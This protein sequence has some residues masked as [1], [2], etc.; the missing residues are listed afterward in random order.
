RSPAMPGFG[1]ALD[2][3]ARW[4][5]IDFIHA[6]ADARR[7]EL[8]NGVDAAVRVPE[9][10]V[11]CPDGS[12]S[13]ISQCA[14]ESC[15]SFLRVHSRQRGWINWQRSRTWRLH[16]EMSGAR[17]SAI[18][19]GFIS[20][21]IGLLPFLPQTYADIDERV[22]RSRQRVVRG[23]CRWPGDFGEIPQH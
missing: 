14:A 9:F 2:D 10:S 20:A 3:T 15:I 5:V 7:L 8:A 13:S 18:T 6:N 21:V 23:C 22:M 11:A 16:C 1:V 19:E 17:L 4:N 12:D